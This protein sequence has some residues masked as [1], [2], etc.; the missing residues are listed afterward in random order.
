MGALKK[1][2]DFYLGFVAHQL[3]SVARTV[4][5]CNP[6]TIVRLQKVQSD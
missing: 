1:N 6:I 5:P 2:W 3:D 4:P